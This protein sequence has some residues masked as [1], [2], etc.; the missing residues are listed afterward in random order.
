[1]ALDTKE[2]KIVLETRDGD[3]EGGSG[4]SAASG[5]SD[6][7]DVKASKD[8]SQS[9]KGSTDIRQTAG[10]ILASQAVKMAVDEGMAW[11]VYEVNKNFAL[12]DNYIAQRQMSIAS[13]AINWGVSSASTIVSSTASGAL[14]GGPVG[15]IV[16]A[17][18]GTTKVVASTVRQ[19]VIAQEQQD[20]MLR[21]MQAQLDFTRNRA[22]WSTQAAS[23]GEDL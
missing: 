12:D 18:L 19:N 9:S 10:W 7:A 15:A 17:A 16:G 13:Q 4:S 22:G 14:V 11:V 6:R 2:I 20:I 5:S 1:M 8:A 21:K 3:S 23:I